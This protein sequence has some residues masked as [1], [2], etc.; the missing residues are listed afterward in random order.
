MKQVLL[1]IF[2]LGVV[3]G[4]G[5]PGQ[6]GD[7]VPEDA[8]AE[9]STDSLAEYTIAVVPK[10]LVHQFWQ[11]VRAGAQSAGREFGARIIW[12]G[13]PRE[14]EVER[15]ISIIED[16]INRNVDLFLSILAEMTK[17][18]LKKDAKVLNDTEAGE[19]IIE[20]V[21]PVVVESFYK[22]KELGRFVLVR[23]HDVV[24]GGIIAHAITQ[25]A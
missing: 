3:A 9:T 25:R 23:G 17:V 8:G 2:L 11:T 7:A 5:G 20:T 15:Q 24:A 18:G 1:P 19:V 22:T 6:Q 21:R 13:P 12:N 16:M 14:T 10:G 4:C